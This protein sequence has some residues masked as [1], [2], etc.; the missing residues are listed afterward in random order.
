MITGIQAYQRSD[1]V[2]T[3]RNDERKIQNTPSALS[4]RTRANTDTAATGNRQD[5]VSLSEEVQGAK[6][7]E[8]MGL[9]I[10]GKITKTMLEDSHKA[11]LDTVNERILQARTE[12][13]IPEDAEVTLRLTEKGSI[14]VSSKSGGAW[15]LEKRLQEDTSFKNAFAS[16]GLHKS[17]QQITTGKGQSS[18][19][20]DTEDRPLSMIAREYTALRQSQDPLRTL[21]TQVQAQSSTFSLKHGGESVQSGA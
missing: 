18:F 10:S 5:R 21:L 17:L 4:S 8:N 3:E 2:L 11:I 9:P 19:F 7:R 1:T 12:A 13:G 20:S 15:E 16:L 14:K 6:L